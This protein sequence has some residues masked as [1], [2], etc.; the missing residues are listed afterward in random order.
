MMDDKDLELLEFPQIREIIAGFTSFSVSRALALNLEPLS[1]SEQVNKLLRQSTEARHLLGLESGFSIGGIIDI[2]EAVKMASRGQVLEPRNLLEIQET[3]TAIRQLRSN[4]ENLSSEFPLLWNI[5][6][7]LV[8]LRQVEKN[9]SGRIVPSGELLD[10]ASPGLAAVRQQLKQDRQQLL[11][12][13][14]ATMQSPR[15]RKIVQQPIITERQGRY[16]LP[17]KI[18]FR[19]EI[20][21]IVHDV[22]NSEATVFIEPLT[23]VESGNTIRELVAEESKE[24][25]RILRILS[26]EVGGYEGEISHSI[27]LVAKLD[28]ALAK[29][30]Y[31]MK[32]RAIEPIITAFSEKGNIPGDEQMS[33]FKLVE[34]RHPLLIKEAVPLSI[35]I[36]RDFNIL[37]IT[38]P[39]T[40]GKTVAL[41]TI[42]LLSLMAQA[43]IPIPAL[44]ESRIPIFDSIFSDI[45]DEQSIEQTLSTFSWHMGNIVRIITNATEKSLVLLDE[46]GTNTDPA[47]GSA[48]ARAILLH[49]LSRGTMTVATTHY[50]DLKAFA[51]VTSGLKNASLD[52]DKVTLKPNYHLTVGIPGGSNAIATASRLGLLSKIIT[53]A[54]SMLSKG[55]QELEALL[56]GLTEEKHKFEDLNRDL[57]RDRNEVEQLKLELENKMQRLTAEDR[58]LV[59][60]TRDRVITEA[61]ELH[62]DIQGAVSALR[63]ERTRAR[64]EQAKQV[65]ARVRQQLKNEVWQV[66][67]DKK[68]QS[69]IEGEDIVAVGDNVK[70]KEANLQGTVISISEERGQVEVQAGQI[71]ITL[72]LDSV[73]KA[74]PSHTEGTPESPPIK[75]QLA[76]NQVANELNL[77]GK[78]AN[79]IE[80]AL[81]SYINDAFLATLSQV[82]IIHGVG[83]GTVRKIARDLLDSHPLV[84]SFRPGGRGE[85]GDGVTVAQ[86]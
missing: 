82:R 65:L 70:L 25:E 66:K 28:L 12:R 59:Q 58:R 41:K 18:E 76:K 14:K 54:R 67:P 80:P 35:E 83:T 81:D 9:I 32:A 72:S 23:T 16:V 55:V 27:D 34:A 48:L 42:G 5:A 19:R 60:E 38:G 50:S 45:G 6:K 10:S 22:S 44:A 31:A 46:L 74:T 63:K 86:L 57:K 56:A 77:R 62:Q 15:G 84:K 51:H 68:I 53:S 30:R 71:K 43:G 61:A 8:E 69:E 78:R 29:A 47:E 49:F 75:R 20:K 37:V 13:L 40:G 79:E 36:G 64:T 26:V 85:G 7:E 33:I 11:E 39:N 73:E 1:D 21:G 52:F 2:R 3:L 24:I 17:I 4:L